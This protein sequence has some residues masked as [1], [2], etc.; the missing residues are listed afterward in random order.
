[1][2]FY[3]IKI[4]T[5]IVLFL[6][7]IF[8]NPIFSCRPGPG[9]I[10]PTI[11]E[12]TEK[13]SAIVKG[14]VH[15][16][17][18]SRKGSSKKIILKQTKFIKGCGPKKI[19]VSNFRSTAACGAGIPKVGD[20]VMLFI[21]PKRKTK[22][23]RTRFWKLNSIGIGAGMVYVEHELDSVNMVQDKIRNQFGGLGLC[24]SRGEC[25]KRPD[26]FFGS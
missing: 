6:T 14:I 12:E 19:V 5:K 4:L 3:K 8:I 24:K 11:E 18:D 25:L 2:K 20:K 13:A 7:F 10:M 15:R 26:D 17:K 1:M 16:V 23:G 22:W 9:Y 21:C